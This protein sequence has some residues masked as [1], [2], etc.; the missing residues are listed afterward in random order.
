[1]KD[2]IILIGGGGHCRAC[3]D[4]IE[5][6]GLFRIAGIVDVKEKHDSNILG[7]KVVA[8]DDDLESLSKSCRNYCITLGQIRTSSHR[9]RVYDKLR[10]L[11]VQLPAIISPKA[12]VSRHAVIGAGTIVMHGVVVNANASIGANCILNTNCVVEHDAKISDFCHVSTA[13]VING[14]VCI[15]EDCFIGSNATV[16]E[17]VTVSNGVVLGAGSLLISDCIDSGTYIGS[18]AKRVNQ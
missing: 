18:P 6:Q 5:M 12:H 17:G 9:R 8:S 3:I 13:A 15:G 2:E 7:Y 1:V 4:V 10:S 16:K 14:G 11:G